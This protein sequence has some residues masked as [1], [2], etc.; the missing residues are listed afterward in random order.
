MGCLATPLSVNEHGHRDEHDAAAT[1]PGRDES[2]AVDPAAQHVLGLQRTVGNTA[3]VQYLQEQGALSRPGDPLEEE[4]DRAARAVMG[5][6]SGAAVSRSPAEPS[7]AVSGDLDAGIKSMGTGEPLAERVREFMEPRFGTGFG[8]VRV[9]TD[10]AANQA[11]KAL[12]AEAFTYGQD[13]YFG[14]GRAPANDALTAHELSHVVQQRRAGAAMAAKRIQPSFTASYPVTLGVFEV[15]LQTREGGVNTPPTHSGFD[16]YIRFVPNPDAPNSNEIVFVQIAKVT[17]VGGADAG[18]ATIPAAQAPRGALGEPGLRTED[19]AARG[20][21]GGYLTDVHHRPNVTAP[22][23]AQGS[24]LSPRFP[25]QPA[26]PG[27]PG[28]AGQTAQPAQYGGGIGGVVG[29][30]PGFKRSA[31]AADI[32]SPRCTTRPASPAPP[33]TST[34]TSSPWPRAR[35]RWSST[36]PSSGGSACARER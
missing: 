18:A 32:R 29:Q 33:S 8:D 16:G 15:D 34:S 9:H 10:S 31:E 26:P 21:E 17:D 4:A 5:S 1:S 20:V 3:V 14:S 25:F 27:T 28:I 6:G 12:E 23:V 24:P 30:T 19:D 22:G 36:G 7:E 13:I 2:P 11:N 35:T